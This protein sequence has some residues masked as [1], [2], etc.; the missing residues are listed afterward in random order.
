L[1]AEAALKRAR[2]PSFTVALAPSEPAALPPSPADE[3]RAAREAARVEG[4][5]RGRDEGRAAALAEWTPRL[6]VLA[7]AFER[8]AAAAREQG[9]RLAADLER[10]V[11][12]MALLLA[13][14]VIERELTRGEEGVRAVT[15]QVGRRLAAASAVAVR[16]APD[17]AHALNAWRAAGSAPAGL[18]DVAIHADASLRPGDWVVETED[19][20]FDGRLSTQLEE[21]WRVLTEPRE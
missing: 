6:T 19:G 13:E 11:P 2:F 20:F 1:S 9:E 5:T 21:A 15:E 12:R 7:A 4:L 10:A 17:L 14:K 8:A 3:L 16:V 18:G